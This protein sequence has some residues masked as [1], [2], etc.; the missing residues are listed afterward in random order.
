MA[1][2]NAGRV[3]V[4]AARVAVHLP[5]RPPRGGTRA[6]N[7]DGMTCRRFPRDPRSGALP[8]QAV[9]QSQC[10]SGILMCSVVPLADGLMICT[11][12]GGIP[13]VFGLTIPNPLEGVGSALTPSG[14]RCPRSSL[15]QPNL[16]QGDGS[17]SLC[18][19]K[20]AAGIARPLEG[21][22]RN[23]RGVEGPSGRR[24]PRCRILASRRGLACPYCGYR[25]L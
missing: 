7:V 24:S 9:S 1:A 12:P 11:E 2:S 6:D 5:Q 20:S 18:Q 4:L 16:A 17:S 25:F 13:A 21:P 14:P 22:T 23:D 3:N 10:R 19:R 8:A 15:A